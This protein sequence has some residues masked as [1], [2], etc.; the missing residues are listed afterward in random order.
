MFMK[1]LGYGV[2]TVAI[3]MAAASAVYAQETTGSIRG[4]VTDD[5]GAAIGSASVS[6]RHEPTGTNVTTVTDSNGFFTARGLRVGGPYTISVASDAGEGV[7]QLAAIGVGD[8]ASADVIVS[9]S[10]GTVEDIVIVG[11][12][13][14]NDFGAGSASNYGAATIQSLPSARSCFQYW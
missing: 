3:A 9:A 2:S 7:T 13:F 10:S 1:K 12:R 4:R 5:G 6:I 8:P 14:S 11:Q